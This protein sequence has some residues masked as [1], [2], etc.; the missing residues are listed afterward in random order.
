[1]KA[2]VQME[3]ASRARLP[4]LRTKS[5]Y[6]GSCITV[7][8]SEPPPGTNRMSSFPALRKVA[9]G[10]TETFSVVSTGFIFGASQTTSKPGAKAKTCVA[11][12]KSSSVQPL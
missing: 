7:P 12:A 4:A 9:V 3:P 11:P 2:P 1:M 10:I 5:T 6:S 8:T